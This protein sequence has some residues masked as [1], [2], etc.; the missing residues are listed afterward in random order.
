MT[1]PGVRLML[2]ALS[3]AVPFVV[4]GCAAR[5]ARRRS[6]QVPA[7]VDRA[8]THSW[9]PCLAG[10]ISAL[11]MWYVWGSLSE[12]G[13][14][15][16]ERAY[17]LQARTFAAGRWTGEVPPL[18]EFF[19]QMHVFVVPHLAAKYPPGHALLVAPGVWLGVPGLMPVLF[20]AIAGGLVFAIVRRVAEPMAAF[21]AWALWSTSMPNLAWRASY[22][23]E[24]TSSA[25]WLV[26]VWALV[27]WRE[28][29]RR[30]QLVIVAAALAWMYLTRPLTAFALGAP[31]GVIVL[32]AASKRRLWPQLV[33]AVMIAAPILFLNF[34]WH[35]RTLG[36]WLTNPYEEYSRVYFPF[37]KPGFGVDASPPQRTVPP[38]MAALGRAAISLHAAHQPAA[39]PGIFLR[40]T[41]FLVQ[42]LGEQWRGFLIV[43]FLL[44]A[45]RSEWPVRFAS[46]SALALLAAYL[47]F[48]HSPNWTVYY[49][50]IFPVFFFVAVHELFR[51]GRTLLRFDA[52]VMNATVALTFCLMMPWLVADVVHTREQ[53][54]AIMPFYRVAEKTLAGIRDRE[55]VVFIHYPP[56]QD[57]N[58]SLIT[59]APD[60]RTERLWLVD[61]RGRDNDRLLRLTDR[62]AYRLNTEDWTLDRLR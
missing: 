41:L 25:L 20:T 47:I 26:S 42:T 27:R 61:D 12:P 55:A 36:D 45:C 46:A 44:G 19:E 15:H 35:E 48:A 59:N 23:S 3:V 7:W 60:Y 54:D 13:V 58:Q 33:F 62:A 24:T 39:L 40:R 53:R 14:V 11:L 10:G 9:A 29:S 22:F 30:H 34:V 50:E 8:L 5:L 57:H 51:I 4:F 37:D 43:L 32:I 2:A 1:W 52:S 6:I 56:G 38:E 31:V 49:V 17:L 18:P 16:D 28:E 21:L